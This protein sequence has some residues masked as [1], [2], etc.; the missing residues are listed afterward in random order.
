MA[1]KG[2]TSC[3]LTLNKLCVNLPPL[4]SDDDVEKMIQQRIISEQE[5][6]EIKN[7]KEFEGQHDKIVDQIIFEIHNKG[8][9]AVHILLEILQSS[10]NIGLLTLVDSKLDRNDTS[11]DFNFRGFFK[12]KLNHHI[13]EIKVILVFFQRKKK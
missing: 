13:I 7:N 12:Y 2:K 3:E 9:G 1:R 10:D 4:I 11:K 5:V 8:S 6:S